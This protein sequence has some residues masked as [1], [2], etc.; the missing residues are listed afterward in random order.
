[1]FL[2]SFKIFLLSSFVTLCF[3]AAAE[4]SSHS[5]SHSGLIFAISNFLLFSLTNN[6]LNFLLKKLNI[7]FIIYTPL[8]YIYSKIK[9]LCLYIIS[10]NLHKIKFYVF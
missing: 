2:I 1:M 3:F 4:H 7:F 5:S 8:L 10:R 9:Y 6:I